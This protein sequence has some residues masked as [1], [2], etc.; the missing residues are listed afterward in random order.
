MSIDREIVDSFQLMAVLLV[1]VFAYFSVAWIRT[2]ELVEKKGDDNLARERIERERRLHSYVLW[3]LLF[4]TVSVLV[5]LVPIS[6]R[7]LGGWDWSGAFNTVRAGLI[8][9]DVFL[10]TAIGAIGILIRKI[11]QANAK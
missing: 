1:F 4:L 2:N 3:G 10:L 9:V 7:V 6:F 8:L 11:S 5:I